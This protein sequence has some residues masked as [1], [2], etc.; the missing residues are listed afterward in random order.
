[1]YT[2]SKYKYVAASWD[3]NKPGAKP[4]PSEYVVLMLQSSL[5]QSL[6][7]CTT[8]RT[9]KCLV[10]FSIYLV[11]MEKCTNYQVRYEAIFS[12]ATKYSNRY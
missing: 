6:F 7:S 3:R 4:V 8:T 9:K 11:A 5:I 1:M 2:G 10:V 12:R